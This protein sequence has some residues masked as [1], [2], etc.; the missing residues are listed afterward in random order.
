MLQQTRVAA[1]LDHYDRFLRRYPT[2]QALAA[3]PE[4]DVLALWSGLGYYRRAR[5]LHQAAQAVVRDHAGCF[6]STAAALRK[7]PGIGDYTSAAIASIAF[8][9]PVAVLDGN[10]ERVL[11]RV[12]GLTESTAPA[13]RLR[14]AA[15]TFLASGQPGNYNQAMMELGATLC[16]P[17]NPL[18]LQCP[19]VQQCATRGEHPTAQRKKMKSRQAAY[20]YLTRT[21]K[22]GIPEVLL[23]QRPKDASLMPGMWELPAIDPETAPAERRLLDLRHAI[24]VT[25]YQVTIYA[26]EPQELGSLNHAG[27][28]PPPAHRWFPTTDLHEIPLTGL[29]RKV[30]KRLK[31]LPANPS[32]AP[33]KPE[34]GLRGI[35]G[36]PASRP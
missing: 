35:A 25:N 7:L 6:P 23:T 13:S 24:T 33:C 11:T 3:A 32:A 26:Y 5:H 18:C 14:E 30:L 16:L 12:L 17:R 20:A 29:A 9:E 27:P 8:G 1:V 28:Q 10:V 22:R 31:A 4:D 34:V 15:A 21:T 36:R 2:V 19:V